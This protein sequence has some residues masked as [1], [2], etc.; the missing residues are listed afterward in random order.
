MTSSNVDD[1]IRQLYF[2]VKQKK[3]EVEAATA[4]P[5]WLTNCVFRFELD[6]N[7]KAYN[8]QVADE[9]TIVQIAG[10]L[11]NQRELHQKGLAALALEEAPFTWG[12]YSLEDW[13]TDL[14][15]RVSRLRLSDKKQELA[16]LEKRLKKILPPELERQLELEEILQSTALQ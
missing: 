5:Q 12:G 10:F 15:T 3:A 9:N 16:T 14:K 8:I 1:Q 7:S 4:K 6:Q 11:M 2:T 13:L